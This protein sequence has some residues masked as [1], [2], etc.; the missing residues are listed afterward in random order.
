MKESMWGYL[1]ILLGIIIM[2]VLFL[3]YNYS[4]ANENDYYILKEATEAAMLESVDYG[5][6]R[7]GKLKINEE[8]FMESFI[9]RFSE[10]SN[11]NRNY[12]IEFIDI[13]EEPP[14]VSIRV[15]TTTG[16]HTVQND[17]ANVPIVNRIDGVLEL[18]EE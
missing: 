14:K 7:I 8:S 17:T 12:R 2:V 10:T 18:K 16:E 3:V 4:S 5:E 13:Y 15:T 9:R 6:W 11:V 1:I